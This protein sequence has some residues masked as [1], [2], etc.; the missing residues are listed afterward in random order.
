MRA[1]TT[2]FPDSAACRTQ[3]P[4]KTYLWA[5]RFCTC[6]GGRLW[7]RS[8]PRTTEAIE[9]AV[10]FPGHKAVYQDALIAAASVLSAI[11]LKLV[12]EI[13]WNSTGNDFFRIFIPYP[14]SSFP[15]F[16]SHLYF[17]SSFL[18]YS[19]PIL[20]NLEQQRKESHVISTWSSPVLWVLLK[21]AYW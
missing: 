8:L 11:Y 13:R 14:L 19:F 20:F 15:L 6:S 7:L 1:G 21:V 9:W 3:D 2:D 4:I 10:N 17:L 18:P 12:E 16:F 5:L